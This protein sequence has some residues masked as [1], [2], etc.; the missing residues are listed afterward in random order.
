MTNICLS[1]DVNITAI[2]C[3][4]GKG[5]RSGLTE[6]KIFAVMPNGKCVLENAVYPFDKC[7][8]VNQIVITAS[9]EDF[10]KVQNIAKSFETPTTVVLGGSTRTQSVQNAINASLGDCVLIHDG[11]RPYLEESA[12]NECIDALIAKG[13]AI[14][15]APCTDTV[16]QLDSEGLIENSSR[17]NKLLAQTP[18]CFYKKEIA[19]ALSQIKEGENFTDEAGVFCKYVRK[20]Y[21][22][23]NNANNK[24]LTY[25][26]DFSFSNELRVGTGFDLHTLVENR[27]L[28]LGGIEIPHT[29]GLLGHS[30]ADVLTHAIMDAILSALSLRD[31]GYHFSDKDNAYKDI[32][33]LV[34]LQRVMQMINEKGYKI[35]NLSAV[36]MAQRPKLSPFVPSITANLAKYLNV[37]ESAIGITCT[38]TEK[39]G[40]VG[41]EEGIAVQAFCSLLPIK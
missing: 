12:V 22:V 40:I 3:G 7:E 1:K 29:K 4:A 5:N 33:S 6:N 19:F 35:N 13:S 25:A 9:S 18:Q 39:I 27:K 10:L 34:L 21:P 32:S 2:I 15:C 37:N 16:I 28:I 38:T 30:D 20:P 23:V 14:L 8:R 36:I 31:I 26:S 17:E 24:K 11:A 41:R